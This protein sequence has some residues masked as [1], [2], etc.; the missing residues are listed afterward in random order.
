MSQA[1][2][3]QPDATQAPAEQFGSTEAAPHGSTISGIGN[4]GPPP[5]EVIQHTLAH[6][7]I[8]PIIYQQFIFNSVFTWSTSDARGKLLWSMPINP[9]AWNPVMAR[10]ATLYNCWGGGVEIDCKI[11]GTGFHAGCL[12][13]VRIPPNRTAEEFSGNYSWSAFEWYKLDPKTLEVA[14]FRFGDQRQVN[15]HYTV[16]EGN[17]PKSWD[18]GGTIACFVDLGLNTASTGTNQ[19][20][21]EIFT[22]PAQDFVFNQLVIPSV[23]QDVAVEVFPSSVATLLSK[24][25]EWEDLPYATDDGSVLQV[26]PSTVAEFCAPDMLNFNGTYADPIVLKTFPKIRVTYGDVDQGIEVQAEGKKLIYKMNDDFAKFSCCYSDLVITTVTTGDTWCKKID[27]TK[28]EV[29]QLG[30]GPAFAATVDTVPPGGKNAVFT[31]QRSRL[32][33]GSFS[34]DFKRFSPPVKESLISFSVSG[35]RQLTKMFIALQQGL[36]SHWPADMCA[37]LVL[38]DTMEDVPLAFVKWYPEGYMTTSASTNS[39]S[40]KLQNMSMKYQS[41]IARDGNIPQNS[42][43]ARN[44]LMYQ[45]VRTRLPV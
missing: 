15:Y 20:E 34:K 6:N 40:Y 9:T 42:D 21:V 11:A 29:I 17:D 24:F 5:T 25:N 8:D 2:I 36:M 22:R 37:L 39:V 16:K 13:F 33:I 30:D 18:I 3:P 43:M 27:N 4:P 23:D 19:I 12:V 44:R 41:M 1:H 10:L 14:T 7:A 35:N 38:Y 28:L 31:F 26:E 45:A 32:A